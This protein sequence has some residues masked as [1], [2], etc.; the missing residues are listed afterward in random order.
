MASAS[1]RRSRSCRPVT[2]AIDSMGDGQAASIGD[3]LATRLAMRG[4]AGLVTDGSVRDSAGLAELDIAI[5]A[6]LVSANL[7]SARFY[8]AG[9]Q[10]PIACGGVTVVPG[11]LVVADDDGPI[12]VPEALACGL[13][14]EAV[15]QERLEA[16]V[17][18]RLRAGEP[19]AGL[20]SARRRRAGGL[21]GHGRRRGEHS[22]GSGTRRAR[23]RG[24]DD[25]VRPPGRPQPAVLA[26]R[27]AR[28]PPI[29]GVRHEQTTVYAADGA[30]RAG[31]GLGAALTT[32]G[33]G[34]ANAAGAFGE[35]AA[36]GSPVV[37]VA[38]EISTKLARPGVVRGVL[39][40]SADQAS[41]FASL[42]K[43]VHRPRTAEDAVAAVAEAATTAMSW[44]RG[45]V[46][47]DIP[48]DVL[49]E[50]GEPVTPVTPR[51]RAPEPGALAA[52]ASLVLDAS[53]IVLWAG[54][55]V[56][57]SGAESELAALAERLAAPVIT[58]FGGRGAI[59]SKHAYAVTLPPHEPEV[60]R[61]LGEADL[62]IAVGTGFD[63]NS[64]RNW[65][66]PRPPRLLAINCDPI[67]ASKNYAPDV[68]VLADAKLALS[69]LRSA[70][71]RAA[72]DGAGRA[73]APGGL[74]A[75]A[76]RSG[77]RTGLRPARRCRCGDLRP[78]RDR[79]LRHGDP[80]LLGRRVR[81]L[82]GLTPAAVPGRL[83]DARLRAPAAVGARSA[84]RPA[85]AGGLRRRRLHVRRRRAAP[86]SPQ[87]DLP[88]DG[89]AASTTA[90]T[91]CS[92]YDQTRS[93][94]SHR[95]VDL[96]PPDFAALSKAFGVPATVLEAGDD[97]LQAAARRRARRA[98]S[99][100]VILRE[101]LTPPRT[102]SPRWHE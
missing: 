45:P 8:V 56:V 72:R 100:M 87:E 38:S 18:T 10:E 94:D 58:T 66:M 36:C 37:L 43:A 91:A 80:G 74:G 12:V 35:A 89:A 23:P 71:R 55:G 51:R 9:L 76:P 21:R 24:R 4:V 3:L 11:D 92:R 96:D 102:T 5:H 31:G 1:S 88:G 52:A 65:T 14:T 99:R 39:H 49:D 60:A 62:L 40:E 27:R 25:G 82:R 90:A 73:A 28:A 22:G 50:P 69:A 30:A 32:T 46:Y 7:R 64:T 61:M 79:R 48:T 63:G 78:R 20:V 16:Y 53:R 17:G 84:A 2:S 97:R 75:A 26:R 42:A 54:G 81:A 44:P 83:G 59:P 67:E 41:I 93:G 34:A 77:Q 95:G 57:Q 101:A 85:R 86:C 15:E 68:T 29:V 47:V 33:P 13:A 70:G 98:P 19:L 6:P